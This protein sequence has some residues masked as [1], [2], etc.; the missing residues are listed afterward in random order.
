MLY[1]ENYHYTKFTTPHKYAVYFYT[2]V[3]GGKI[4]LVAWFV[5]S[6]HFNTYLPYFVLN[7]LFTHMTIQS[8]PYGNTYSVQFHLLSGLKYFITSHKFCCKN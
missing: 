2:S 4:D 1:C 3:F 6:A 7:Y 5:C 8:H